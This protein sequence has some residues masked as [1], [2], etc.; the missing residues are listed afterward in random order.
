V[1]LMGG[2]AY[3]QQPSQPAEKTAGVGEIVVTAE[4]REQSLQEVPVAISAFTSEKRDQI[5]IDSVQD[6][7]NFTPGFVYNTGNDRVSMRGIGRYTNQLGADSSV[8]V[9]EDGAFETFTVKAGNDSIFVDRIEVLRGP[10]GTLYGRN[11]IG[12]AVNII[13]RRPTKDWYAEVRGSY[14]NYNQHIEE[15]A[16]SGP[17]GENLQFRLAASKTD[18]NKGYFRNIGGGPSSGNVRDEWYGEAQLQGQFN[19]KNDFWLKV[20]G[21]E[22]SNG[23]GNAGGKASN[24]VIVGPDGKTPLPGG[25][26]PANFIPTSTTIFFQESSD[27]LVPSLGVGFIAP[28][29]TSLNP[30]GVNPGNVDIRDFYSNIP[31]FVRLR[32]YYGALL[33]FNHHFE[34]ADLKYIGA[35]QHYAYVTHEE[36]GEGYQLATGLTSYQFPGQATVFPDSLLYY[37]EEHWFNTNEVNLLSTGGGPLQWVVGVYNFNEK[38]KQPEEI[39]MPGQAEL[40]TPLTL[41]FTPGAPNPNRDVVYQEG[42]MGAQTFAGFGQIDWNFTPTWKTTLGLRYS[43]DSKWGQ[44]KARLLLFNSAAGVGLDITPVALPLGGIAQPGATAAVIDPA[45]GIA[46]RKLHGD[47]QDLTGTAG[48]QWSPDNDTNFYIKYSRGYKSGGFNSGFGIAANPRTNPENSNDYQIGYKRNFGRTLQFNIAAFYD[49][50]YDAQIPI[51]VAT[52]SGLVSAQ[53]YNVPESRSDGVEIETTWQATDALQ[54]IF[55]YGYNDTSIVKSGCIVDALGDPTATLVGAQP[56]GCVGGAQNLKG[57]QLPNAPKNKLAFN[58]N[59]TFDFTAGSLTLSASYIWRDKQFG[60][61]FNRPY[62]EAPSWDQTDLR[63]QFRTADDHFTFI[64]YGKNIFDDTGYA[65]GSTAVFQNNAVGAPVGF[66]KDFVLTPPRVYGVEV[67]YR[68]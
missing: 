36:W 59:Y 7:T 10:Q 55:N 64:A 20:F 39:A 33:Q 29:R 58:G 18:Q 17:L 67:Q 3:A 24:Q 56:G 60:S 65:A 61:I 31:Q 27:A 68:F 22:W 49:Q 63:A 4:K 43:Y 40:A 47:W 6:M 26:Y 62:T 48:L 34:G 25:V 51:G 21:G 54:F 19:D 46:T 16:I 53:F 32:D 11:S 1:V 45:T 35:I 12:G 52:S 42:D 8:G 30:T 14:D 9:Y 41:L 23:G 13:S 5:G 2:A 66:I 28:T 44:D 50:Y 37:G 15:G 38:Y 57:N